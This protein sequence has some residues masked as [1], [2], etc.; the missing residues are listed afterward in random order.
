ALRFLSEHDGSVLA[1]LG[2]LVDRMSAFHPAV[3]EE[4]V[5]WLL[6]VLLVLVLP[7]AAIYALVSSFR[8]G[9]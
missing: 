4:P 3:L 9:D 1:R 7:A 2:L 5:I 6:L 8:A